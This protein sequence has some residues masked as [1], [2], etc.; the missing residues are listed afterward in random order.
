DGALVCGPV[1]HPHLHEETM[2]REEL[3]VVSGPGGLPLDGILARPGLKILVLRASCSYRQ[4]LEEI[5]A[6]RGIAGV[7]RLEF[8]TIEAIIGCCAAGI[9]VTLLPKSV[10]GKAYR[11]HAVAI[12]PLPADEAWVETQFIRHRD[13]AVTSALRAFLAL[14]HAQGFA[15][16]AE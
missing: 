6:R 13:G 5:L 12:H 7:R 2:F 3:M 11:G 14:I 8:G 10:V 4:R 16:A 9:G 15:Q 1:N